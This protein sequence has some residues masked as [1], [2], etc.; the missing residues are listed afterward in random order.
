[1]IMESIPV[2]VSFD[3][4]RIFF[5]AWISYVAVAMAALALIGRYALRA[6]QMITGVAKLV[7]DAER[8]GSVLAEIAEQFRSDS[9]STLRDAINR[10]EHATKNAETTAVEAKTMAEK[11][12]R[13]VINKNDKE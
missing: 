12:E 5:V 8:N 2:P 3:V 13:L 11:L 7:K 1:M 9:G 6:S 4:P 10:I